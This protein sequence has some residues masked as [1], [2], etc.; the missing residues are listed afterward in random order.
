MAGVPARKSPST[1]PIM[2]RD[3]TAGEGLSTS[4]PLEPLQCLD[5]TMGST[6]LWVNSARPS[7]PLTSTER[8]LLTGTMKVP[9]ARSP[10]CEQPTVASRDAAVSHA[11]WESGHP[12][13]IVT[14]H[15]HMASAMTEGHG[16]LS[17][18]ADSSSTNQQ[19]DNNPY[20]ITELWVTG[21]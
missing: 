1:V 8:A 13:F 6:R 7:S 12:P 21:S 11:G 5:P 14:D 16:T 3:C 15:C 2:T 4:G 19:V 9:P 20:K 17:R 18:H 10:S